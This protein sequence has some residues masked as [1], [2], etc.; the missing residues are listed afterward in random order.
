LA[1][2][3]YWLQLVNKLPKSLEKRLRDREAFQGARYEVLV[4]ATFARAG[5]EIELLDESVKSVKHCEFIATHKLT[6]TKVYVE[7]KSRRRP[8]VL[9][10]PG[11][12]TDA[13]IKGDLFGLYADAIKQ[14]PAG[15]A[16]LIFIDANLPVE[17]PKTVHPYVAI[18]FDRF[19]WVCEFEARLKTHWSSRTT[20]TPENAVIVTDF[21]AHFGNATDTARTG[22]FAPM[23]SPRPAVPLSDIKMQDDIFYCLQSYGTIPK[24]F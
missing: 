21:A 14:A 12:F 16:Y 4:A 20:A 8:G 11:T 24:Q 13:D 1:Y 9:H 6:R 10:Q 19:P 17:L 2:D 15:E 7:A 18:S 3:L 23:G 5:F 22:I